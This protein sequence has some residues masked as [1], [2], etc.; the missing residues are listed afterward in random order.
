[1]SDTE[2][3][4]HGYNRE[5]FEVLT[6]GIAFII[7]SVG[8]NAVSGKYYAISIFPKPGYTEYKV[9]S[10]NITKYLLTFTFMTL[11]YRDW[12]YMFNPLCC[13]YCSAYIQKYKQC[14]INICCC[15]CSKRDYAEL[16]NNVNNNDNNDQGQNNNVHRKNMP[17]RDSLII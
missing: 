12:D 9:L 6:H 1:M 14:K 8:E 16:N 2:L 5:Q 7:Q 4:I 13:Y 10:G 15:C 17:Y 11:T 3:L